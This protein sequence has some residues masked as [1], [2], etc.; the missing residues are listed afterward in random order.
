MARDRPAYS[1]KD[2]A[3]DTEALQRIKARPDILKKVQKAMRQGMTLVTTDDSSNSGNRSAD[4]F[5]IFTGTGL[6]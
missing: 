2:R 1:S 3:S 5:T 6:Y 4:N